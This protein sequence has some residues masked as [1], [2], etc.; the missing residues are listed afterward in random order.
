VREYAAQRGPSVVLQPGAY[1][2]EGAKYDIKNFT[3]SLKYYV[4]VAE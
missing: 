4:L 3:V 1:T 2:A